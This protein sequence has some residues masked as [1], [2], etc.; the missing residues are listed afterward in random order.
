MHLFFHCSLPRAVWFSANPSLRAD[1][2]PN[3]EHGLHDILPYIFPPHTDDSHLISVIT[4][5][6]YIWRARN[7]NRFNNRT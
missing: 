3:I 4:T 1:F 2:L 7:D 6:W 5:F